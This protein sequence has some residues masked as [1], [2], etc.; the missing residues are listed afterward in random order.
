LNVDLNGNVVAFGTTT[1]SFW[2][3]EN[4]GDEWQCVLEHL[5]PIYC[6]RFAA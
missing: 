4:Q 5:S 6:L 2:V 1:F 3:S